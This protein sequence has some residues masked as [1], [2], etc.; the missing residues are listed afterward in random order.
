MPTDAK[1]A[2][3]ADLVEA[4]STSDRAIVSD[5]RGLRVSELGLVRRALRDK[6]I[7]YRVVK[8]RLARIAAE[9]AGRSELASLLDGPSAVALGGE[10]EVALAKGLL[11][12]LRPFR[13]VVIRGAIVGGSRIDTPGITRMA[14]L[15]SRG[16]LLGGLAGA[17]AAPLA[18]TAGLFDAPLRQMVGLFQALADQKEAPAA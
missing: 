12:A 9:Q 17:V 11:E 18:T 15:P 10:D 14:T 6:G 8:N 16:E 2:A 5:Y 3:V 13:N 1:R 4:F 7:S